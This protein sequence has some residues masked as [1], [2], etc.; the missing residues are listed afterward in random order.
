MSGFI[1]LFYCPMADSTE[2]TQRTIPCNLLCEFVSILQLDILTPPTANTLHSTFS[3]NNAQT[4]IQVLNL[5]VDKV[6]KQDSCSN[7]KIILTLK[8]V[9]SDSKLHNY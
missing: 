1:F 7:R 8:S 9:I 5:I 6:I 2:K 3:T 4:Y